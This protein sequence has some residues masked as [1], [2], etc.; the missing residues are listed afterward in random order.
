MSSSYDLSNDDS[1]KSVE[2]ASSSP[3]NETV[4]RLIGQLGFSKMTAH[5]GPLAEIRVADVGC[6][7]GGTTIR[8]LYTGKALN[9][10]SVVKVLG[11]DLHAATIAEAHENYPDRPNLFFVEKPLNDPVP[12]IDGQPYHLMFAAFV[13]ET[14]STF[15]D[16]K[17]LCSQLVDALLSGGEIYFL[18]LHPQ[19]LK[20]GETFQDYTLPQRETWAHGDTFPVR[21]AGHSKDLIDRFWEPE[22]LV[23]VFADLG[24]RAELIP[25]Q[26]GVS[27]VINELLTRFIS[28]TRLVEDM[29]EWTVPLYQIVRVVKPTTEIL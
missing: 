6:Y 15:D 29:P 1:Y 10:Q 24:C 21:L 5:L 25:I 9:K 14:I 26:Q 7:T 2:N 28:A 18:R 3:T 17:L 12:L 19:A 8:W 20:S 13:V 4:Y 11:F 16:V 22:Q 23:Q 27:P